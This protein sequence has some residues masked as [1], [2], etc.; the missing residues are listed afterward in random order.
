MG[1][2]RQQAGPEQIIGWLAWAAGLLTQAEALSPRELLPG[3]SWEKIRRDD[4]VIPE[5]FPW[6]A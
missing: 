1:R 4:I 6:Q 3:F 2:L 5:R